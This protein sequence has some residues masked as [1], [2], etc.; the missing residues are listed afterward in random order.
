MP[1][2]VAAACGVSNP[3][4]SLSGVEL[5]FQVLRD[6]GHITNPQAIM[7][8][9]L[10]NSMFVCLIENTNERNKVIKYLSESKGHPA[11]DTGCLY[12]VCGLSWF[13]DYI[14]H[15]SDYD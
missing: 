9:R 3:S 4:T 12:T 13:N 1:V 15:L 8:M 6:S 2:Y 11:L 7:T 14:N 5:L 10:Y